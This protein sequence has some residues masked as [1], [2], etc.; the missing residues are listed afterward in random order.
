MVK[1]RQLLDAYAS[2]LACDDAYYVMGEA[3]KVC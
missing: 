3:L 1:E 2:D